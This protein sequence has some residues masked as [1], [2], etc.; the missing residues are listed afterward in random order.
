MKTRFV[1]WII[2]ALTLS[3]LTVT[4]AKAA[5]TGPYVVYAGNSFQF[6]VSGSVQKA[7]CAYVQVTTPGGFSASPTR[8][9]VGSQFSQTVTATAPN[10]AT[11]GTFSA[12]LFYWTSP[13]CYGTSSVLT[14][15]WY[16]VQVIAPTKYQVTF[17][18]L[19][20]FGQITGAVVSVYDSRGNLVAQNG[21]SSSCTTCPVY[22]TVS[23]PAGSYKASA[24]AAVE[25]A[26]GGVHGFGVIWITVNGSSSYTIAV[27]PA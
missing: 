26:Y 18:V 22:V 11:S 3:M 8:F 14:L 21:A 19:A 5:I 2:L 16:T 13:N 15:G 7:Y 12:M 23:L 4:N 17:V 1:A 27:M 20:T 10:Y 25:T 6:T 24:Y 9:N